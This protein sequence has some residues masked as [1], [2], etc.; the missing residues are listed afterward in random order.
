MTSACSNSIKKENLDL[1]KEISKI[2]EEN[3]E[4][5]KKVV[6][7]QSENEDLNKVI[8]ELEPDKLKEEIDLVVG[9]G[10]SLF[11]IY[12]ANVDT[13]ESEIMSQL[14]MKDDLPLEEKLQIVADGLSE[15]KFD[16]LGIEVSKIEDK[17]G[18]KIATIN[19]SEQTNEKGASW[20]TGYFQGSTG[21]TITATSL[22][23]TFLQKE[24][25]GEWIDG[26]RFLY[27][28]EQ[29][30]FDHVEGLSEVSYR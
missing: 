17:D 11:N 1:T 30:G 2:K 16:G 29:I 7:L 10:E 28:N 21:G 15:T 22:N 6:E 24:Y 18:R 23:N 12:G 4:L 5:T 3:Q 26:V 19:L 27:N 8:L 14:V 20:D 25:N 13:Y 9:E